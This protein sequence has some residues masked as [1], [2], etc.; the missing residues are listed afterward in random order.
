M[1]RV[2]GARPPRRSHARV[3]T[4]AVLLVLYGAVVGAMTMSPT[5]LDRGYQS[6]ITRFLSVVHRY[7]VPEW[8]GYRQLEFSANVLMFVPL[9][10]LVGLVVSMRLWWLP[11]LVLPALSAAIELLQG[12]L[13]SQRFASVLDV[14]A[15]TIGGYIGLA[16]VIVLR[17]FVEG[18]D[19]KVIALAIWERE[20]AAARIRTGSTT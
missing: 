19:R 13:L 15:N 10:F 5:P 7:G 3:G 2:L 12:L 1:T 6:A 20:T 17:V 16:I 8:F 4:A 14:V 11:L 18:R 9:G